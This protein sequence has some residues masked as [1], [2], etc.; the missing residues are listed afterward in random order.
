M[1]I[2]MKINQ[3]EAITLKEGQKFYC[4]YNKDWNCYYVGKCAS[5]RN[6]MHN[7]KMVVNEMNKQNKN[8]WDYI[9]VNDFENITFE[10]ETSLLFKNEYD[11]NEATMQLEKIIHYVL[12]NC[13]EGAWMLNRQYNFR[14]LHKQ[15]IFKILKEENG[16]K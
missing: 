1:V 7:F 3:N 13:S 5:K 2:I 9:K 16:V 11:G 4:M 6:E 10:I 14:E 8:A 12:T 15:T